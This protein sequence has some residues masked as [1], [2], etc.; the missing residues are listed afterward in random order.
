[1]AQS[2]VTPPVDL[3]EP[4]EELD[5]IRGEVLSGISLLRVL[6][7]AVAD[8]GDAELVESLKVAAEHFNGAR[9]RMECVLLRFSMAKSDRDRV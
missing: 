1:M 6:A 8:M 9:N 4:L 3:A 7:R 5:A 2:N